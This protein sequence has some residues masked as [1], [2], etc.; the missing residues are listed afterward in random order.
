MIVQKTEPIPYYSSPAQLRAKLF[1]FPLLVEKGEKRGNW[2]FL[3]AK[4]MAEQASES[5]GSPVGC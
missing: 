2:G 1:F 5:A 4:I 3:N